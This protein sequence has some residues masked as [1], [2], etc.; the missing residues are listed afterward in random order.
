MRASHASL[1]APVS[2]VTEQN[3]SNGLAFLGEELP[4]VSCKLQQRAC[5][6]IRSH[7]HKCLSSLSHNP[8]RPTHSFETH[9]H[10]HTLKLCMCREAGPSWI[11]SADT[12][13]QIYCIKRNEIS[14]FYTENKA[15]VICQV[16]RG[17]K[18][19]EMNRRRETVIQSQT[20]QHIFS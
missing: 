20:F 9:T 11:H 15:A 3:S 2:A 13:K 8:I 19:T 7:A 5:H 18:D 6:G 4:S 1:C 14:L 10:T 17:I 16:S 12:D